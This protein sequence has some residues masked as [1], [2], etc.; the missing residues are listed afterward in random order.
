MCTASLPP[1]TG[2]WAV[3]T[4]GGAALW[5]RPESTEAPSL[6]AHYITLFPPLVLSQSPYYT[7]CSNSVDAPWQSL[8][9]WA[10]VRPGAKQDLKSSC[11]EGA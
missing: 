11:Q 9:A 7:R 4:A 10:N 8:R 1:D 6:G 3:L 2:E 5:I